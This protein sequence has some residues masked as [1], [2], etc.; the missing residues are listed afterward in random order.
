MKWN[1]YKNAQGES[2]D[3]GVCEFAN[4]ESMLKSLRLLDGVEIEED[5]ELRVSLLY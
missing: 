4:V 3:R 5:Y 1:R 2:M